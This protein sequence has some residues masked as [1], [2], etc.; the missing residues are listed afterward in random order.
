MEFDDECLLV[1]ILARGKP[2]KTEYYSVTLES[3]PHSSTIR[4]SWLWK[5]SKE[6]CRRTISA[7]R[8]PN[9]IRNLEFSSDWESAS[10]KPFRSCGGARR[11]FTRCFTQ[12]V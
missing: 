8:R 12:S 4:S 7:P 9:S 6:Y 5:T 1:P 11:P 3:I 2:E 10:I